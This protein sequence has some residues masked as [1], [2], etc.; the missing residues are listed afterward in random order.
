M[1]KRIDLSQCRFGRLVALKVV[2]LDERGRATWLCKCDCGTKIE[3][4]SGQLRKGNTKSC[5]CLRVD[6]T[7]NRSTTHGYAAH[8]GRRK[9]EYTAWANIIA[10]CTNPKHGKYAYY[11]GRGIK[12]A[13]QW[14]NS[15]EVFLAD[16]GKR[17]SA[18]HSIDRINVNGNYEPGN[19]RW[20]T[21]QQQMRN[22]RD[23]RFITFGGRTQ[24]L[25]DWAGEIGIE[26]STLRYRLSRWP[27]ERALKR[28]V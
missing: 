1:P 21:K 8:D 3:C 26:E 25:K 27:L 18:K 6:V 16:I 28:R 11:G 24:A 13:E 20:A 17:P 12:I 7:R 10:R 22:R 14:L 19:V 9:P 23:N 2:S 5:G 4:P 15:F